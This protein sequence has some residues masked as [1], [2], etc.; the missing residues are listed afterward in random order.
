MRSVAIVAAVVCCLSSNTFGFSPLYPN[1]HACQHSSS[2]SGFA[3]AS[4]TDAATKEPITSNNKPTKKLPVTVLSG[5]LGAGKTT[6]L[7]HILTSDHKNKKYAV[8]VNDMSELNIDESLIKPH[9]QHQ[10][11]QLV[12][13]SNGCICCTLREDLLQEVAQLARQNK[14]DH[15][16]IESTGISEPLPVAETFTFE[17][18]EE[19][20]TDTDTT[21]PPIMMESLLDLAEI[22]SMVTVVDALNFLNDMDNAEDL[23]ARKLEA[24]DDD[25]R[26]ITDLLVS[27]VEFASVVVINK[28]DAVTSAELQ[29]IT[30]MIK[31]LNSEAKLIQTTHSK[32]DMDELIGTF[33][34]DTCQQSPLWIQ[35]INKGPG[36]HGEVVSETEEYGISSFVFRARRPFHPQRLHELIENYLGGDGDSDDD[37][38]TDDTEDTKK[39]S[40]FRVLRS[41]GFFWLASRPIEMMLWSQAGGLFQFSPSGLWWADTPQEFWPTEEDVVKD[42]KLDYCT[43]DTNVGDRRQELVFIGTGF[44]DTDGNGESQLQQMLQEALLTPEEF[45]LGKEV[46]SQLEDPFPQITLED[47]VDSVE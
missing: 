4:T 23:K 10:Q 34:F 44:T 24:N 11:E 13:M 30:Q 19:N 39:K 35:E 17:M 29:Q 6:L 46:W 21:K 14:F 12:E 42:I 22:D 26:T 31:S 20:T 8:I 25:V 40:T 2:N 1:Q 7:R 41:K 32:V 28:C 9:V 33:D 38:N 3:L 5:F 45:Q 15:L 47:D 18:N 43:D 16:L 36:R 27:Q 37:D